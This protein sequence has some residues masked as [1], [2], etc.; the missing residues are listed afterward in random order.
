MVP[1]LKKRIEPW[2]YNR[3]MFKRRIEV[4]RLFRRLKGFRRLFARFEK[5]DR[6]FLGLIRFV[7]VADSLW[8]CWQALNDENG[9][10]PTPDLDLLFNRTSTLP[11]RR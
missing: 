8:L 2:E 4:E 7:L 3:E 1:P 5:I 6:M 10:L 9:L 11:P